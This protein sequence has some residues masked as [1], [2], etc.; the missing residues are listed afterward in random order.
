VITRTQ[1]PPQREEPLSDGDECDDVRE[2]VSG[3]GGEESVQ[4]AVDLVELVLGQAIGAG[5][6]GRGVLAVPGDQQ[7]AAGAQDAVQFVHAGVLEVGYGPCALI[8][9]LLN[10]SPASQIC[11]VDPSPDMLRFAS[12]RNHKAIAAG[13]LDLRLGT[14]EQTGFSD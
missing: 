3:D 10:H 1:N 13:R 8:Q 4:A 6:R 14:A 2:I 9:L 11:G 5:Y 12:R 7:G